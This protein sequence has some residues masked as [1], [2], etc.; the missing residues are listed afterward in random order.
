MEYPDLLP[1]P[2]TPVRKPPGRSQQLVGAHYVSPKRRRAR[3]SKRE[4]VQPLG[5]KV[6]EAAAL[7]KMHALETVDNSNA[8]EDARMDDGFT[9]HD[10]EYDFSMEIDDTD[11]ADANFGT[12]DLE[13]NNPQ[14]AERYPRRIV[15][16]NVAHRLFSTW[17]DVLTSVVPHFLDYSR[18]VQGTHLALAPQIIEPCGKDSCEQKISF[19]QCLYWYCAYMSYLSVQNLM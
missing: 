16:N 6:L 2:R 10:P 8:S 4:P 17:K 14:P 5:H 9:L 18:S 19:V 3:A 12:C 15:P 1:L 13:N 7:A 11:V